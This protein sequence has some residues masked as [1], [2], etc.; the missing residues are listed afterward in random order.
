[1]A[2]RASK[3]VRMAAYTQSRDSKHKLII[4][5]HLYLQRGPPNQAFPVFPNRSVRASQRFC[6]VR[7]VE[8]LSH[9]HMTY[10]HQLALGS[11]AVRL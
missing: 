10:D 11:H 9:H 6:I 4:E 7:G 1:M 5:L 2:A 3:Q 8:A